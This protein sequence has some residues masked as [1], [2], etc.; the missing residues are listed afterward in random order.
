MT[1]AEFTFAVTTPSAAEALLTVNV[2]G[3]APV[4]EGELIVHEPAPPL[5]PEVLISSTPKPVTDIE[6]ETE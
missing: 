1:P 3:P 6:N 4:P 2:Y 5:A